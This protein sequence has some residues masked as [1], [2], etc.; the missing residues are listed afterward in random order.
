VGDVNI[1]QLLVVTYGMSKE[2]A[3]VKLDSL[4]DGFLEEMGET[5]VL[6]ADYTY[7]IDGEGDNDEA[8]T[9]EFDVQ[10]DALRLTRSGAE[11]PE[12]FTVK[13]LTQRSMILVMPNGF[14]VLDLD[15]DGEVETNCTIVAELHM[16]KVQPVN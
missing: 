2:E 14:E 6:N 7:L 5:L 15:E 13:Q 10:K 3:E 9:W 11:V 16:E 12:K 1:T 8:G 4:V